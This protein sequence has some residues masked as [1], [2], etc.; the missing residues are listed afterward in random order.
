M[1]AASSFMAWV[2]GLAA[3]LL[4][5][6]LAGCAPASRIVL[7]PQADA[8]AIEV[9]T[10]NRTQVLTQP[11]QVAAV[12]ARG[13][14]SVDTTTPEKVREQFPRL[15]ALQPATAQRYL[16]Y[17]EPGG[18]QLT[19]ESEARLTEVLAGAS[20]RPGGE[21]IVTGH[22]DLVGTLESNDALSLQR[23]AAIRAVLLQRGFDPALV[24]AVGRGEREP[25]VPTDDEVAEP[26]NRRAE[27][28]VR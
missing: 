11:Y 14:V 10:P 1:N 3:L 6:V 8:T 21:I 28:L 4:A 20:A 24:D 27:V 19:P 7:L 17:F 25:L 2:Q 5:A 12:S 18:S 16:L 13:E 9:R 26:R 22:T 23:A 15:L